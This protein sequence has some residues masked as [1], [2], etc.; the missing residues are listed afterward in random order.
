MFLVLDYEELNA[1]KIFS[2]AL[3]ISPVLVLSYLRRLLTV[4]TEAG[5]GPNSCI[6]FQKQ[7]H[8]TI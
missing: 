3:T 1:I 6:F 5:S 2:L 4:D 8:E 7:P